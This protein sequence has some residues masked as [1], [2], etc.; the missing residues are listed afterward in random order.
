MSDYKITNWIT[1][2]EESLPV[3]DTSSPTPAWVMGWEDYM[4]TATPFKNN[5]YDQGTEDWH[6][7]EDGWEEAE[8]D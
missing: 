6:D 4:G 2:Q 3:R 8:R 5:P 7:Y 1:G